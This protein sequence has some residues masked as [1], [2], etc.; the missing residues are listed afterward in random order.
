LLYG[1]SFVLTLNKQ[2][3]V[4]SVTASAA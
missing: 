4:E 1:E 2:G 3:I